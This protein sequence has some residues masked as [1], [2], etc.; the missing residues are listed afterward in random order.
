MRG[1]IPV[2]CLIVKNKVIESGKAKAL[3]GKCEVHIQKIG[4]KIK[5]YGFFKGEVKRGKRLW[6]LCGSD[7][8]WADEFF[9]KSC[10]MSR[11]IDYFCTHIY[12]KSQV[13][14]FKS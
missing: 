11:I 13:Q 4:H 6:K 7:V 14:S 8:H 3:K 5:V 1:D 2:Y 9:K 10:Q 12:R